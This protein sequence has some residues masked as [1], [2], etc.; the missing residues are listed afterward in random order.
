MYLLPDMPP[1]VYL[2]RL[3]VKVKVSPWP[4]HVY[5]IWAAGL[6]VAANVHVTHAGDAVVIK[7]FDELDSIEAHQHIIVPSV[8][9]GMHEEDSVRKVIIVIDNVRKIHLEAIVSY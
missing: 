4:V 2:F 5:P 3:V 7:A 8:S 9:M 6:V 1:P